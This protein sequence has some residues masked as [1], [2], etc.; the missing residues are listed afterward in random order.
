MLSIIASPREASALC[1]ARSSPASHSS[2]GGATG[3]LARWSIRSPERTTSRWSCSQSGSLS[4]FRGFTSGSHADSVSMVLYVP[5]ATV[6][7]GSRSAR[8]F[9]RPE[10]VPTATPTFRLPRNH[11]SQSTGIAEQ[12]RFTRTAAP[13]FEFDSIGSSDAGFAASAGLR[14]RSV[15]SGRSV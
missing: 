9:S 13:G 1:S 7:G 4:L 10:L 6:Y 14:W 11:E 5:I 15:S 8:S 2:S 12:N 3:R